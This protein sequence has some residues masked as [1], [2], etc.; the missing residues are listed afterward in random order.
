MLYLK[1][2]NLTKTYTTSP[3]IDHLDLTLSKGEKIAIVAKNGWGKST[4]LKLLTNQIDKTD[5][6]VQRKKELKILFLAQ[7][8]VENKEN[9]VLDYLF[10]SLDPRAQLI[11][12][13]ESS[14]QNPSTFSSS[15][16]EQILLQIEQTQARDYESK[17]KTIISRLQLWELLNQSLKTLSWWELK[18]CALAKVL[19]DEPEVLILDEPTNHLDLQMIEWL[20]NYLKTQVSTLLM[21]TH[22]RY[23]LESV[24]N[25]IRE[26]DRGKIYTYPGNYSYFLE[27]QAERRENESIEMEKM[28]QLLKR[29]LAWMR[30]APRA[31]AT[32]QQY[33]EK[34]FYK[35]EEI[36]DAR[37][38]ILNSEKLTLDLPYQERRLWTKILKVKNL[39]K[40]FS[41][42]IILNNF[43]YD[44]KFAERIWIIGKNWAWKS[45][46][47]DTLLWIQPPD[48]WVIEVGKTVVFGY[49]QQKEVDFPADKRVIDIIKDINEY[50]ILWSWEKI[51][52]SK[53][54]E[55][56]LFPTQQQ[57]TFAQNLSWWEK[58]RLYLLTILMKNPNFLILDE[59]TNDLDLLTLRVLEDFLLQ[60]KGCLMIISH[61]RSFMDR[62]VDHLFI[63]EGNWAIQDFRGTYSERKN[64]QEADKKEKKSDSSK[65]HSQTQISPP[66]WPKS[67]LSYQE[68]R[69][70][71]QLI[72]DLEELEN[73]KAEINRIFENKDLPY[74][75]IALLS[76]HLGSIL[77]QIEQKE[78]RRFE[79]IEKQ[80]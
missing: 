31:R 79:L 2:Q 1:T 41:Q 74:D 52:A 65:D 46:F 44:F 29:E 54:L 72:K 25:Q 38:D 17:V 9:T 56:F 32:K 36:Y 6:I 64:Q 71:Q 14:L 12:N 45:T 3:I 69:E 16:V 35:L 19:I 75:E 67:K 76:E 40:A 47:I 77:K 22:D 59:P 68:E 30:K 27:K 73:E 42:K 43:T 26:L 4:L 18:R 62:L 15:Q 55:R 33:R 57:F 7:D 63:F 37:K 5:G 11:K 8:F 23:F 61:D 49:Y 28:R 24:C 39:K 78:Y 51:P 10:N 34:E 66:P 80:G 50:L 53:I 58:R 60:F 70:L 20:E 13:Y 48:S 21:I